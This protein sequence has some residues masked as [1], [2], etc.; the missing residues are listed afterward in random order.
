MFG[1]QTPT[2]TGVWADDD[3]EWHGS[4]G[5]PGNLEGS[6]PVESTSGVLQLTVQ[7]PLARSSGFTGEARNSDIYK[8][9]LSNQFSLFKTLAGHCSAGN[10]WLVG[11]RLV[12]S[13]L[14]PSGF[15]FALQV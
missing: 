15:F 3:H 8:T 4:G 12:T 1:Q 9:L 14:D 13:A 11:C 6:G 7:A 5:A 10:L 2:V